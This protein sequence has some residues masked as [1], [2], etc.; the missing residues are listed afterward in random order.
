MLNVL[1][2]MRLLAVVVAAVLF[3][4]PGSAHG[5]TAPAR[6]FSTGP[7]SAS[8]DGVGGQPATP[9]AQAPFPAAKIDQLPVSLE[10]IKTALEQPPIE[11]LRGLTGLKG[12]DNVPNFT[13][14]VEE[15]QRVK[16][17]DLVNSLD[18][19]SGPVPPGG[20][21]AYEQQRQLLPAV[22]NPLRQPYAEFSQP[23]LVTIL[24]ENLAVHY[25]AGRA[26]NAITTAERARAEAQ[27][28]E[29]VIRAVVEYCA[30]QPHGGAGLQI[31]AN[32]GSIR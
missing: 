32:P 14:A 5:Q 9:Q 11:P 29:D 7:S 10:K 15:R 22:N 30:A 16:L 27:A 19:K 17:E 3:A 20:L 21:Y 2:R 1:I 28:R 18:F 6:T 13:I 26:A 23:E 25:L 4:A 8:E 12:L 31:C 24:T